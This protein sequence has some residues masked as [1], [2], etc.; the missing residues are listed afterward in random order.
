MLLGLS[1]L[2]FP[3]LCGDCVQRSVYAIALGAFLSCRRGTFTINAGVS[4]VSASIL[5][6]AIPVPIAASR[7]LALPIFSSMRPAPNSATLLRIPTMLFFRALI[8]SG[9]RR[10]T[11]GTVSLVT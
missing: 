4:P 6:K 11:A 7:K 8:L 10:S 2:P 5:S 1:S 9:A 3:Q